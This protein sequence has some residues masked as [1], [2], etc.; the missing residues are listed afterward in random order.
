MLELCQNKIFD[1]VT[2]GVSACVRTDPEANRQVNV[3]TN[4][5][6]CHL[7]PEVKQSG[8]E[9]KT[10]WD[11]SLLKNYALFQHQDLRLV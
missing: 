2:H 8:S 9:F 1:A 7:A 10:V 4:A 5:K 11:A 6:G 3:S